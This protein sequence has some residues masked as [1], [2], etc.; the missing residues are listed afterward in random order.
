MII[1]N[2]LYDRIQKINGFPKRFQ[3]LN[4]MGRG[5]GDPTGSWSRRRAN[6][7]VLTKELL[8]FQQ[9]AAYFNVKLKDEHLS[10]FGAYLDELWAWNKHV[11]ITGA[12]TRVEVLMNL[13]LD[14][15]I[16]GPHLPETGNLL[17]VGSG[18]G[19]P[20]IPLKI[21]RPGLAVDLL[22]ANSKRVSFLKHII[23]LLR[24]TDI[25]VMRER[26]GAPDILP[27]KT[28]YEVV[29][30][31]ALASPSQTV[32]W[33]APFLQK[34]GMLIIFLGSDLEKGLE[35]CKES[36]DRY[37]MAVEKSISY[38]L[39]GKNTSR[40]TVFIKKINASE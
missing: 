20:G 5:A 27:E 16:P 40:N 8:L 34:G 21:Y 17:D 24:L 1:P 13:F 18:G 2:R 15:L 3:S 35:Q 4:S 32:L 30:A 39:P 25:R 7:L 6:T 36:L 19:F 9:Q 28:L 10:L 33:C 12:E 22:E 29:T 26:I 37:S 14:S 23:R 11:N 38:L 31:R